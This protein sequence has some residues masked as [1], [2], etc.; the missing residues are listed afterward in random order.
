MALGGKKLRKIYE[1]SDTNDPK[2]ISGSVQLE[3]SR[4]FAKGAHLKNPLF[5]E[6]GGKAIVYQ[7]KEIQEDIEE[8]R[9]TTTGSG[10]LSVDGGSF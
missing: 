4:S 1:K 5:F 7:I 2:F 8:L 9:R 6:N 3:M 10:E